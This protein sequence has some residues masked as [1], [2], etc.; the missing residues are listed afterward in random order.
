MGQ[1]LMPE[2]GYLGKNV[3]TYPLY[4]MSPH[5]FYRQ[6][7][8][9]DSNPLSRDEA[10]HAIWMSVADATARGINDNDLVH[11]Y[12][13]VGEIILPAYVTSRIVPGTVIVR[14]GA[15]YE[16]SQDKTALMPDG[17]DMRGAANFLIKDDYEG[18]LLGIDFASSLVQVE[19]FAGT[20][21]VSMNTSSPTSTTNATTVTT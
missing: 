11:V 12:N 4:M 3:A 18:L 15:W 7:S 1:Y 10:R 6:H 5:S 2:T 20:T 17:I 21:S 16:P 8:A 13:D 14:F 19:L 9:Q